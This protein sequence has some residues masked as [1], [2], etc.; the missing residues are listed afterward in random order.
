MLFVPIG[1]LNATS[2][3]HVVQTA[4]IKVPRTCHGRVQ[5]F[6]SAPE[7]RHLGRT[8]AVSVAQRGASGRSGWSSTHPCMPHQH[9]SHKHHDKCSSS[10]HRESLDL[11]SS[12]VALDNIFLQH[13]AAP[14]QVCKGIQAMVSIDA[15]HDLTPWQADAM[16]VHCRD[17]S[18]CD[19]CNALVMPRFAC[20][21]GRLGKMQATATCELHSGAYLATIAAILASAATAA[22]G[23]CNA[24]DAESLL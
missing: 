10:S 13:H 3:C 2:I 21:T 15:L 23:R 17:L 22:A 19:M 24:P 5:C 12:P 9:T 20:H 1:I 4:P 7:W 8:A 6:Y 14:S 11:S 18:R 16:N